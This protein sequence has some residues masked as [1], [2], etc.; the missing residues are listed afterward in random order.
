MTLLFS[1]FYPYRSSRTVESLEEFYFTGTRIVYR[2]GG[3]PRLRGRRRGNVLELR[4]LIG[5]K[6]LRVVTWEQNPDEKK[7]LSFPSINTAR[8]GGRPIKEDPRNRRGGCGL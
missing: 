4:T 1:V 7:E 3:T 5:E 2:R 6:E 8:G